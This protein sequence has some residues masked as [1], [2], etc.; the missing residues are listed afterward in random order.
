MR[1]N[2]APVVNSAPTTPGSMKSGFSCSCNNTSTATEIH[3]FGKL[4]MYY[5]NSKESPISLSQVLHVVGAE[6]TT[7]AE[8][9]GIY[10]TCT[11]TQMHTYMHTHTHAHT[12][13]HTYHQ[14]R[15]TINLIGLR[16]KKKKPPCFNS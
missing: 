6:F 3:G 7:G 16:A 8:F 12:H 11:H 2:S 1:E 15:S 13:T 9:S 5:W 4:L 10:G 14:Y